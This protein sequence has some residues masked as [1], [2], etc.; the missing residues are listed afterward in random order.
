MVEVN[1]QAKLFS[2]LMVYRK[3]NDGK[4]AYLSGVSR[5]MIYYLRKG[6][7]TKASGE[8][9]AKLA[10]ALGT[11]SQYLMGETDDV[12]PVQKR[13]SALVADISGIAEKLPPS[14]QRQYRALGDALLALEQSA[15]IEI[16]YSDLMDRIT[17][18]AEIDGGEEA[19]D[20]LLDHL[21]DLSPRL[22][23]SSMDGRTR[24]G[25]RPDEDQAME[26]PT[27]GVY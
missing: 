26:E 19:L 5:T 18:L 17:R 21:N 1:F 10:D 15:N 23:S 12:S 27:Q 14:R 8:I 24:S 3:L 2:D 20:R 16:I 13:M 11:S 22:P 6:E 25:D 9:V 7:R 4:L